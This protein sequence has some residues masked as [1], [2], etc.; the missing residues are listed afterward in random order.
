MPP[1]NFVIADLKDEASIHAQRAGAFAR[2]AIIRAEAGE[3]SSMF[4]R[5]A[6]WEW[7]RRRDAECALSRMFNTR[8]AV[9]AVS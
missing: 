1:D 7:R 9:K 2:S 6:V 5:L 4:E 8:W 3:R